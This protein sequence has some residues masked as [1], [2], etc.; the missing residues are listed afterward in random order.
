MDVARRWAGGGST[1]QADAAAFGL[2]IEGA[3]EEDEEIEIWPENLET[4]DAFLACQTQW[5]VSEMSG[6]Y[7]GLRYAD[8]AATLDMMC[9]T[10][11]RDVFW[12]LRVM[13]RAA[14]DVLRSL[15]G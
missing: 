11:K 8:V 2:V 13:E 4:V 10:D 5:A 15:R 14:L 3:D 9:V 6:A 1:L 12:G 7:T